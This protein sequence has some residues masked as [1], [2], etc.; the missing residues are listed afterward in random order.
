MTDRSPIAPTPA[1][2]RWAG[3][4]PCSRLH[5]DIYHAPDAAAEVERAFVAPQRLTERMAE[6]RGTFTVGELGFGTA[7]NFAVIAQRFLERAPPSARLHFISVERFPFSQRDFVGLARRRAALPIYTELSRAYP[8]ML[9]GWHRRQL[10]DGRIAL[11]L[12]FGDA[13]AGLDDIVG[14]QRVPIDAWLLDGFAPDRNPELWTDALWRTLAALSDEGTTVA[15]FSAVGAVRRGLAAAGFAMRKIDQRPFKRHSLAGVFA[16]RSSNSIDIAKSAV[17]V[18][19]G[20]AGAATAR[21]LAQRGVRVS[22][23]DAAAAPPNRMATTLLHARLLPD[24]DPGARLR[25]LAYLYSAHWQPFAHVGAGPTGALQFA[26]QTLPPSRFE[27]IAETY[28]PSG[29]WLHRVDAASASAIAGTPLRA[30]ALFF[31]DARA[32]D[33]RRACAAATDHPLIETHFCAPVSSI[34]ADG[35]AARVTTATRSIDCDYVVLCNGAAAN[36][37][38][39]ARFLELVPVAG[40]IDR[41]D[42][43]IGAGV[44]LVGDG[45][46]IPDSLGCSIGATYEHRPWTVERAS[47]FNVERLERWLRG[48]L[49][50][51]VR[52]RSVASLRGVRAVS[53]DRL[54][55][56]GALFDADGCAVPRVLVNAGHGSHGTVSAPFAA[57]CVASDIVGEFAPRMRDHGAAWSSW[58]FRER[59][60]RRGIRHGARSDDVTDRTPVRS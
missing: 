46:A 19:A 35:S 33:L 11:S 51:D 43:R 20:L 29:D 16:G 59:Q 40:Q 9:G 5:G 53:S 32:L 7:L 57:E 14:R 6:R 55:I 52:A 44:P 1:R 37:F 49:G 25:G 15:T 34:V 36:E 31:R 21:Q 4:Q 17:V 30:P 48:L 50:V 23:L 47:A 12:F 27:A 56:V 41:V 58:R 45:F 18:G 2:V 22:L 24:A 8:P 54:P 26:N 39:Q 42:V 3:D 38:A 10:A 13:S 60:A 28:A